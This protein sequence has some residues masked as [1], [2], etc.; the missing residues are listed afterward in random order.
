LQFGHDVAVDVVHGIKCYAHFPLPH[1]M[2][3]RPTLH[4]MFGNTCARFRSILRCMTEVGVDDKYT[5][6]SGQVVMT[7]VQALVRLPLDQHRRDAAAGL[8][9]A[10]LVT[11]YRGSPLGGLDLAFARAGDLVTQHHV[12]FMNGVNED[13]AATA[14]Y[15][16]QLANT[17]PDPKYDGVLGMWYG[18]GPGVDRSGDAFRHA[19]IAGV[20]RNGGVLAVAGDDP[21]A[22]SSTVPSASEFALLD[23]QMPIL[24]PSSVQEVLEYGLYG[25][26]MSRASGAW[27]SLKIVTNVADA[28]STV[29]IRPDLRIVRPNLELDGRPWA[30]TQNPVLVAPGSITSERELGEERMWAAREFLAVNPLNTVVTDPADAWLG[31]VSAGKAYRDLRDAMQALGLDDHA[32]AA[33]GVR[34][35][36]LGAI[37]PLEA[38]VV[39][40][41]ARGLR[42]VL[43]VEEKRAF[44]ELFL[45]DLL[46]GTADA[47]RIVGKRDEHGTALLPAHGELDAAT[48]TR[49]LRARLLQ[50]VSPDR[51]APEPAGTA[52]RRLI[53]L[54]AGDARTP[55]FCSGCPHNRSTVVPEGSIA[56]GSVGCSTMAIWMDRGN[57]N[58]VQMGGE[59]IQWVGAAP[60]TNTPHLFQNMGDG[61]FLHSGSL[62]LRQAVAAGTN[63]TYKLLYN[64]AV[65]MTGGQAHDAE[66]SMPDIVRA[67]QA[68]GVARV[69]VVSDDPKR[70]RRGLPKGVQ[71]WHRDR[72]IE[73]QET[74]RAIPGVTVMVYDQP[75]AAELRRKRKRG[76]APT[77]THRIMINEAVCEGCGDCGAKSNCL[78]VQPVDTLLG[79]KTRIHQESCNLDA[80]C[81]L[82]HCPAFVRITPK[83]GTQRTAPARPTLGNDLPEP[84][85]RVGT[86]VGILLAGIGGT[87]VVTV[88]QVLGMAARLSGTWSTGLDQTGLAQKG[89]SVISHVRLSAAPIEGGNLIGRAGTDVLLAFDPVAAAQDVNLARLD[90]SRTVAVVNTAISPTGPMVRDVH[91]AAPDSQSLLARLGEAT[92]AHSLVAIDAEHLSNALFG[93][94]LMTNVILLGAAY[95]SGLLPLTAAAIEQ[96]IEVNGAAVSTNLAAF[97]AGRAA[98][99]TPDAVHAA[100]QGS[101]HDTAGQP[102]LVQFCIDNLTAYQS[103]ALAERFRSEVALVAAAEPAGRTELTT[104][105]A[106][107]LHHLLAVKD[108]YEVARL[109]RSPQFLAAVEQQFGKGARIE[110]LLQ[111]PGL[112]R[113]GLRGKVA[114]RRTAAPAFGALRALKR[115]RG[116]VLDVFGRSAHR[117]LERGLAAEYL[118]QVHEALEV[119]RDQPHRYHDVVALL[120]LA[121]GVRGFDHVKERNVAE[122]RAASAATASGLRRATVP[123]GNPDT[124]TTD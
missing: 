55:Y 104:T 124:D 103:A 40:H 52:P 5:A 28:Y 88:S 36:K 115:T 58:I 43:V 111:P 92:L 98:V 91:A 34:L 122:W 21:S 96:A 94:H 44:V 114:L 63:V 71:A 64:A 65:A 70:H 117:R 62:A 32:L 105:V 89:G 29:T 23:A 106:R 107:N 100:V 86:D 48:V 39:R 49:V 113:F 25:F 13:L 53:P 87:G 42:E 38:G 80:S 47:P 37:H 95:Q 15:G 33:L 61:T 19:N 51:L 45:R 2:L 74:L 57:E 84:A 1:K 46:Y 10:T 116:T 3:L 20:G 121:D 26:A 7:G 83:R 4:R 119:L 77:P 54:T 90:A 75:C 102:D 12:H 93:D 41:F 73:A 11:G 22:K 59:G 101:R 17:L 110:Y 50:R 67:L 85:R 79:R 118:A 123:H 68:E 30:H 8:H 112:R 6:R 109:H 69:L 81:T 27:V 82:G 97:R 78:S 60:F 14:I 56:H 108:E 35:L 31:I 120:A 66:M 9:T 16:S 72:V 24:Y 99:A 18:K 76:L